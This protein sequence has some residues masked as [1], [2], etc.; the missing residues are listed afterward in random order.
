VIGSGF[1][2]GDGGL[3]A[4]MIEDIREAGFALPA[5]TSYNGG[6]IPFAYPPLALYVGAVIPADPLTTLQWLPPLLATGSIVLVFLIGTR[7]GS[8]GIGLA[9]A[10][11]YALAPF[12]WYWLVQGGGITRA[13]AMLLALGSIALALHGRA[14][15]AGALGGLTAL[16]HPEAAI[17]AAVT[18]AAIFAVER[19]WRSLALAGAISLVVVGPWVAVVVSQHGWE[20]FLAAAGARGVNP[21]AAVL[22]ISGGRPGTLDLAAAIGLIGLAACGVRWLYVATIATALFV[23]TSVATHLAPLMALGVGVVAA[24]RELPRAPIVA[25]GALLVL[26]AGLSVGNPEPLGTDDRALMEW[27][28]AETP[29]DARFAVLSEEIWSRA[30]EAEWFPQQTG[31]VSVVTMQ[32]REWLPDWQQLNDERLELAACE[33]LACV[34]AWMER[35][36]ADYVYLADDCCARLASVMADALVRQEGSASLYR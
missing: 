15:L 29:L 2:V 23:S 20:P 18:V 3:F 33:D 26:G 4:A 19:A 35:N 34:E 36:D 24:T 28:R 31:R 32:G 5:F 7:M 21:V 11:F 6:D 25:T 16:T 9:A 22:S 8:A 1:P 30:D 14:A 17:F 27:A 13:M 10:A 12:G